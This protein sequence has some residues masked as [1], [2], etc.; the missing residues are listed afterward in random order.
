MLPKSKYCYFLTAKN[1]EMTHI[2]NTNNDI[3][4]LSQ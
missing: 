3:N 4:V 2:N 1:T